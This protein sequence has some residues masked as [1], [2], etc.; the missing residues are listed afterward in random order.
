MIF[1]SKKTRSDRYK[2]NG[3]LFHLKKLPAFIKIVITTSATNDSRMI[4]S[5]PTD[6]QEPRATKLKP[7]QNGGVL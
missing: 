4:T 2:K 6:R 7:L 5:P 1:G 3:K